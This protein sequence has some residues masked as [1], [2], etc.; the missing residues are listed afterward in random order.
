MKTFK[1]TILLLMMIAMSSVKAQSGVVK[2]DY[3]AHAKGW[4][5]DINEAYALSEKTGKPILAN[6]TGTDWC[7]WC[8]KLKREVFDTPAFKAWA[9]KTVV[10]IEL[11]FPR[12]F[13]LPENI[14]QQNYNLAKAFNVTGYPTIWV[15]N[16]GKDEKDQFTIDALGKTGYVRGTKAFISGVDAMIVKGKK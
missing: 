9:E 12:K 10:L 1:T 8:V 13:Q 14:K 11:D 16:L 3:K 4:L 2:S 6:F 7:G 15:F 5:V